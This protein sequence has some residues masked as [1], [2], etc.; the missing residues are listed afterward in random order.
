MTT[1]RREFVRALGAFAAAP[2]LI[3]LTPKGRVI[4]GGFVPDCSAE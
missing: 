2:A 4:G 3:G 1:S